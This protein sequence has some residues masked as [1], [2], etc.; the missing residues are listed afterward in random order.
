MARLHTGAL[1]I[2]ELDALSRRDSPAHRI[3]PRAKLLATAA[4]LATA[5]SWGRYEIVGLLPLAA[6]PFVL[7]AL[8]RVPFG[9][10][11]RKLLIAAPF[12]LVLGAFNPIFD[13]APREL[14]AGIE[15]SGGWISYLS[16]V[17]RFGLTVGA[18]LTLVAVTGMNRLCTAASLLGAPRIFVT[19]LALLYRYLFVL[20]AQAQRMGRAA[21]LR[22]PGR[23]RTSIALFGSLVGHLLLRTFDRA[24]RI[25]VAMRCR[26]F[27]GEIPLL[28][29]MRFGLRDAAFLA[30][31]LA[32]FAA[33]RV[34][35]LP[36]LAGGLALGV[37]G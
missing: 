14:A 3:D 27:D 1:E 12:V 21:E 7:A 11:A 8:G 2:G 25:H 5:V 23:R 28:R 24:Q 4:F 33:V 16:I 35:R 17:L 6:F 20:A 19:Q 29:P 31:W 36:E 26:G 9:F 18:A 37:W 10:V 30:A 32:F 13:T 15:V 34:F 22:A